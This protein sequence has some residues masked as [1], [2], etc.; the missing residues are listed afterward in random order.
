[1]HQMHNYSVNVGMPPRRRI[2][3]CHDTEEALARAI[4]AGLQL[5]IYYQHLNLSILASD[6]QY[7]SQGG[8]LAMLQPLE[9]LGHL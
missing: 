9:Q 6:L 4:R 1:M 8:E 2:G 5:G 7:C 3:Q